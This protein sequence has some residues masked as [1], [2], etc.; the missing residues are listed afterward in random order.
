MYFNT[1]EEEYLRIMNEENV[2]YDA[3]FRDS[4]KNLAKAVHLYYANSGCG[5]YGQYRE[6]DRKWEGK[7]VDQEDVCKQ[8]DA[9]KSTCDDYFRMFDGYFAD[10]SYTGASLFSCAA[11]GYRIRE[12]SGKRRPVRYVRYRLGSD[13]LLPLKYSDEQEKT[14]RGLQKYYRENP[15][16][17][18][19]WNEETES[20]DTRRIEP[21]RVRSMYEST[22]HGLYHLHP[23]LVDV[24]DSGIESVLLCPY[25][26]D[27][28]KNVDADP[29]KRVPK[30][31][32][33]SGIDF[34]YYKRVG[35]TEPNLHEEVILGRVR[36]VIASYKI[37]SNM[38]G[39]R[40]MMRDKLQCNAILFCQEEFEKL[41][42]MLNGQEMFDEKGLDLLLQIFLLDD[43]GQLDNL[44]RMAHG[45]A[46]IMARPIVMVEW[47]TVLI[48]VHIYYKDLQV[49][50]W[51]EIIRRI[52]RSNERILKDAVRVDGIQMNEVERNIG[53]DVAHVQQV[54]DGLAS[55]F[56]S[57]DTGSD[58][59]EA[60]G[61]AVGVRV[62]CAIKPPE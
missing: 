17:V 62:S 5:E 57:L 9:Q 1:T 31:S 56:V 2:D 48:H 22:K 15:V 37:K 14:V 7:L 28:V 49:P 6:Y 33:A 60:D 23:E 34:G 16:V 41:S 12:R 18:P 8:V 59:V 44:I 35:L 36:A 20:G 26:S 4:A 40:N 3:V 46:D 29:L 42:N 45:R 25:C 54:D 43:K 10:H 47:I 11:C 24:N 27:S 30:F 21:W 38:C 55:R 19:F 58:K 32:I 51:G 61:G 53:V 13:E 39:C 52:N 50:S